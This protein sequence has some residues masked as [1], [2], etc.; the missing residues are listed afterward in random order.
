MQTSSLKTIGQILKKSRLEKKY[1]TENLE[2]ITKIKLSFIEAIEDN[3]WEKLPSFSTVLGFVKSISNALDLEE[4]A[5]VSF[6]KRDYIPKTESVTP[7][8]DITNKIWFSPRLAFIISIVTLVFVLSGYLISQYIKFSSA[9]NV[10]L[11]GP[12]ENQIVEN[13]KVI[14]FG[15]TDADVKIII[16]NQP[17]IVD[18]E[19]KF[20]INL[21]VSANTN[22]IIVKGV[23]RSGKE[24]VVRRKIEV[25]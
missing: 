22:E 14:V 7:K 3:D 1:S 6:L 25:K 16:N 19:G 8:P 2:K 13:G 4:S 24:T 10:N 12:T 18:D 23:S 15:K 21:D 11:Q 5:M 20:S 17:I 9:P